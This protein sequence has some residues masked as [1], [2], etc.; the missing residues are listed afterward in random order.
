M[1]K[2]YDISI[3]IVTYNNSKIIE[4]TI[5]SIVKNIEDKCE[6]IIYIFDN[7]SNDNTVELIKK[8]NGN[9]CVIETKENRGFGA[10]H[11]KALGIINSKYH[12]IV[13]PDIIIE[14]NCIIEMLEYMDKNTDV[15]M[16]TPLIKYPNGEIQY[17]CKQHP[18]VLD[19]AIRLLCKN[20]FKKRQAYYT[21][22]DTGYNKEFKVPYASGC[23]MFLRTDIFKR[24]NGFDENFFMY[25]ED[26]DITRRVNEISKTI[27]Y[28]Y[29]YVIHE[30][31]RGS[32]KNKKLMMISLQS[33]FYYFKKWGLKII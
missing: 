22:L 23:F 28:P 3:G 31:A 15:G 9:I 10:G 25:M 24:I 20:K 29:N 14:N 5:N 11:N 27:F 18:T 6:Y 12:I 19:Q 32:H 30:W 1:E 4:K 33:S 8:L 13:N 7:N 17:L 21:M 2:F 16:L 26:A